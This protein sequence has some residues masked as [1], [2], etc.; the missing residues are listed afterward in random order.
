MNNDSGKENVEK[1]VENLFKDLDDS[2]YKALRQTDGEIVSETMASSPLP[3]W[4]EERFGEEMTEKGYKTFTE[5]ALYEIPAKAYENHKEMELNHL[6][7]QKEENSY[8][9]S[10]ELTL[11]S[12]EDTETIPIQG[13]AQT[14]EGG[15]VSSLNLRNLSEILE[16][17][18]S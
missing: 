18:Q 8:E 13:S 6:E 14:D 15:L 16:D 9:I 10:G 17:F 7:I 3:S 1:I 11:K 5:T 4:I 12:G 2:Q